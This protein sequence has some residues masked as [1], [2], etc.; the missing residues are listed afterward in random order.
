M[1]KLK[2]LHGLKR[3]AGLVSIGH[4]R[5]GCLGAVEAVPPSCPSRRSATIVLLPVAERWFFVTSRCSL[6]QGPPTNSS[7][8]LLARCVVWFGRSTSRQCS[9]RNRCHSFAFST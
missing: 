3:S 6:T 1:M 7:L 9:D 2:R 8:S 5:F 4:Y